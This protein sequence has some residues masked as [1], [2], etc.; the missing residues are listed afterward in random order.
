MGGGRRTTLRVSM[1]V[2]SLTVCLL[3]SA[4]LMGLLPD[5]AKIKLESRQKMVELVAMQVASAATR[6]DVR[7]VQT[8][9]TTIVERDQDTLS[10]ALRKQDVVV[11]T[12]G[13]HGEYWEK[14]EA[15]VIL[16]EPQTGE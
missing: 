2:A 16:P 15:G 3:L 14:P 4:E 8:I 10:A 7:L 9:L 6:N 12:A 1:G 11:A 13:A 5:K